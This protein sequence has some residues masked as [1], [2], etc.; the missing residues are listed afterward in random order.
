MFHIGGRKCVHWNSSAQPVHG[1]WSVW[2]EMRAATGTPDVGSVCLSRYPHKDVDHMVWALRIEAVVVSPTVCC[3]SLPGA[4][5][6][7]TLRDQFTHR[8][9]AKTPGRSLPGFSALE[10]SSRT[11]ASYVQ[12]SPATQ[13]PRRIY[14]FSVHPSS[15]GASL[16]SGRKTRRPS[17]LPQHHRFLA[18]AG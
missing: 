4:R 1:A 12:S 15:W 3:C 2:D 13:G 6:V 8:R 18:R 7:M 5:A 10:H 9:R 16:R 14:I 11:L 17:R